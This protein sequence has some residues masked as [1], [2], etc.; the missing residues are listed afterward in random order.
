VQRNLLPAGPPSIPGL[1]LSGTS[2]YCNETGGDYYDYVL[3]PDGRIGVVVADV[4]GH[5][6]DAALFMA[7]ARAFLISRVQGF[8]SPARLIG[9]VNRYIARDSDP[10]G[11]FMS[12]FFLEIDPVARSL[13]WVRA[14]HEPALYFSPAAG[15]FSELDG[16]GMVLGVE[17]ET[18]YRDY[19]RQGWDAGAVIVIGTDG[20]TETRNSDNELFGSARV[21]EVIRRNAS[22]PAAEIQ[23]AVIAA[24]QAHRGA[25]PQEDDVTLVVVKLLG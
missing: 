15:S 10:T 2:I 21:R 12:M 3:L 7:S 18:P 1:E 14:G 4:S 11:R 22:R 9:E 5:G 24:V 25:A 17:N 20:I 8:S 16:E 6:V 19:G 23:A 13:R